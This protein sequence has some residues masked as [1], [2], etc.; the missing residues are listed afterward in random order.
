MKPMHRATV[1]LA[2]QILCSM[3]GPATPAPSYQCTAWGGSHTGKYTFEIDIAPCRVHWLEIERSL[4]ILVC[5]PPIIKAIKPFAP[6]KGY[7]LHFNMETGVFS[8]HV[9]GWADRGSC[10]AANE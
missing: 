7:E 8:D 10:Q 6:A 9:P 5:S 1:F 4:E 3:P 2:F